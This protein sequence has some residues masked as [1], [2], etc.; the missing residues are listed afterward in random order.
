[1]ANAGR[2][3]F[4]QHLAGARALE[5]YFGNRQWLS[6]LPGNGSSRFHGVFLSKIVCG[7]CGRDAKEC[8]FAEQIVRK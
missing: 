1:V 4:D 5:V 3:D 8:G 7:L 6:G 2:L